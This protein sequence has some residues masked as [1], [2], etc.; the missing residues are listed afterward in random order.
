MEEL[1][2]LIQYYLMTLRKTAE[3]IFYDI[4]ENQGGTICSHEF[5]RYF[6]RMKKEYSS[7]NKI[8]EKEIIEKLTKNNLENL[9]N[10]IDKDGSGHV[11]FNE[12]CGLL[13]PAMATREGESPTNNF[14]RRGH[15]FDEAKRRRTFEYDQRYKSRKSS[16]DIVR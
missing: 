16:L 7:T 15:I 13:G 8:L 9:F 14:Q 5:I 3:E 11:E 4:D 2:R 6:L 12:F 10:Y 1:C